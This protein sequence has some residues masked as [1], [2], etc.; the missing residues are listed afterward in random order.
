MDKVGLST[1]QPAL[2]ACGIIARRRC[3]KCSRPVCESCDY[4]YTQGRGCASCALP[5]HVC[6]RTLS[7]AD[8]VCC[9]LCNRWVHSQCFDTRVKRTSQNVISY[10]QDEKIRHA[11]LEEERAYCCRTCGVEVIRQE[12]QTRRT[13][14]AR[15]EEER[16]QAAAASAQLPQA[17]STFLASKREPSRLRFTSTPPFRSTDSW[18]ERAKDKRPEIGRFLH[19]TSGKVAVCEFAGWRIGPEKPKTWESEGNYGTSHYSMLY[20]VC[21]LVDGRVAVLGR[22]SP[23]VSSGIYISQGGSVLPRLAVVRSSLVQVAD[24]PLPRSGVAWTTAS[25]LDGLTSLM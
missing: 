22:D 23:A 1:P 10:V 3:G 7:R 20:Q 17:V 24:S 6:G 19:W 9:S 18:S 12:A 11:A 25:L 4:D 15:A 14:E 16:Q 8:S 2:C 13:A 5:C 21:L